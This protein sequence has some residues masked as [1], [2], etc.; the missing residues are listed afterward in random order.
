MAGTVIVGAVHRR[1]LTALFDGRIFIRLRGCLLAH[2]MK[3][4]RL[5]WRKGIV[6]MLLVLGGELPS[7]FGEVF[8]GAG[9]ALIKGGAAA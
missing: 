1:R 2:L 7:Q 9:S 4:C 3:V 5:D 6:V 8:A